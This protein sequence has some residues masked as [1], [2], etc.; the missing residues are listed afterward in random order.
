MSFEIEMDES[1]RAAADAVALFGNELQ[2]FFMQRKN[3]D[4][5]TQQKIAD[6]LGVDKSRINRCLS[7]YNNLTLGTLGQL[8]HAMNGRI[9]A[10]IVPASQEA[11]WT[12]IWSNPNRPTIA[13]RENTTATSG[14][15]SRLDSTGAAPA[16]GL[17]WK[18]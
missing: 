4:G 7:G 8:V 2:Q 13:S 10:K 14:T 15:P 16:G 11:Q 3:S 9:V 12:V 6:Q 5:L 1:D 18:T 17:K